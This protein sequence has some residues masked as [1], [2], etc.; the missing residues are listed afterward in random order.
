MLPIGEKISSSIVQKRSIA[1]LVFVTLILGILVTIA[2]PDLIVLANQVN[3]IPNLVLIIT[4]GVGVGVFLVLATLRVVFKKSLNK[5]LIASYIIVFILAFF[6]PDSF[7]PVAFDSGGVTTGPITVP[8]IM[9]FGVGIA[10]SIAGKNN[11]DDSF[12]LV[13]LCSVGPII[14]MMI[15]GIIFHSEGTVDAGLEYNTYA[16]FAEGFAFFKIELVESISEI[17]IAILPILVFFLAFQFF[18]LHL[19]KRQVIR[20]LVGMIYTYLGIVIFLVAVNV[21]FMPIGYL[22]GTSIGAA[23]Y[24]WILVP[25]GFVIGAFVV[26]AEPAVV[27]LNKQV[28]EV[29]GGTIT[30]KSM[31]ISLCIGVGI[32][33]ALSML[34]TLLEIDIMYFLVPCYL[35]AL[36]LTF[37]VPKIYTAIAFDSGG[38]ASGPM[39]STFVLALSIGACTAVSGD[40]L[41]NAFGIIAMVAMTPLV[42]IQILGFVSTMKTKRRKAAIEVKVLA[43]TSYDQI[44]YF[45]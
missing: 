22:I 41:S 3:A 40:I 39:T 16:T 11:R 42:T 6:V 4:V 20:I 25:I 8:F 5:I 34:R 10:G 38:V 29:S 15:L 13:A 37:F 31:G 1:L 43:T 24:H 35:I 21:G 23:D 7:L 32:S 2:E 17:A 12:G 27:V 26:L 30:K 14:S 18:I 45:D 9:A 19:P 44:I 36:I 28:E 33:I